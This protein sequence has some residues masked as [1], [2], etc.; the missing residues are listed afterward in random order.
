MTDV[1]DQG[2][3]VGYLAEFTKRNLSRPTQLEV[4]GENGAQK[5]ER[6]LLFAGISVDRAQGK[7]N[8]EIM[9]SKEGKD[10]LTHIIL[11]VRGVTPKRAFD[12]RD[13]ALEIIDGNGETSL[14]RFDSLALR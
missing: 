11:D 8:I 7:P 5:E 13:E 14:L 12:G 10:H 1:I 2:A 3:W 9:F 4:F 6:G